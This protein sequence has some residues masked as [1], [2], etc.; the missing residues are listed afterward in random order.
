MQEI[1]HGDFL[2]CFKAFERGI[3]AGRRAGGCRRQKGLLKKN[4]AV[5]VLSIGYSQ[6]SFVCFKSSQINMTYIF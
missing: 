5:A 6:K 2:A 3:S 1:P 4:A